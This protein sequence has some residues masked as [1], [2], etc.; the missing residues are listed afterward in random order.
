MPGVSATLRLDLA[1]CDAQRLDDAQILNAFNDS[2]QKLK[3]IIN[4]EE[5]CLSILYE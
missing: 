2:L 3:E 4:D 5:A 1:A